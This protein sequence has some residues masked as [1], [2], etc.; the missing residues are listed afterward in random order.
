MLALTRYNNISAILLPKVENK[1]HIESVSH[2]VYNDIGI[3]KK[4]WAM[5]ETPR[6][7]LNAMNISEHQ[8][9]DCLVFGSNDLTKD[10]KAKHTLSREP[11]LYA[12]S[13]CIL[14]ARASNKNVLDGVY[15]NYQDIEGFK[16]TCIQGKNLGFDG[17]TLIHP[18][19]IDIT[20]EIF[21]PS[22][23][24][25]EFAQKVVI[26]WNN[27]TNGFGIVTVDGRMIES[28]HYQEAIEVLLYAH[29]TGYKL[30]D[31]LVLSYLTR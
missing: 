22:K 20:N 17:K 26:A 21:T 29:A 19:Q 8:N 16:T 13:H 9:I 23:E 31:N 2:L 7:V 3:Y 11:L 15:S 12:M 30:D 25:I 27:Q 14:A 6:G 28:L 1:D 24:D 18:S 5:I 10:I 4:L